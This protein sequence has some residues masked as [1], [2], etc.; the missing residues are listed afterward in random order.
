MSSPT[1]R[2]LD[3]LWQ[4]HGETWRDPAQTLSPWTGASV[5]PRLLRAKST[6]AWWETVERLGITLLVT[7]EYEHLVMALTVLDGSPYVTHLPLPHP[8]GLVADRRRGLV[9]IAS[10]RN[11][12]QVYE[13]KPV[14]AMLPRGGSGRADVTHAPLLPFRSAIYPGALYIHDLAY[15][16][17]ELHAN[18]VGQNAIVHLSADGS[19]QRV[20][21]P[22]RWSATASPTS[23]AIGFS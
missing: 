5:D 1:E 7:R 18:S 12:N 16:G 11:P 20:W 15:I 9:S 21:W 2:R 8:S 19:H 3:A 13:L 17:G 6:G 10:T 23:L 4:I 14:R 22:A